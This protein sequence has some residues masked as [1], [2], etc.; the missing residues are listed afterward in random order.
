MKSG[1]VCVFGEVLFDHFP[2]GE[3]V[4][5]GAPFNVAWH[6]QAFGRA[7]YLISRVGADAEGEQ[8]QTAMRE[9]N[10]TMCGVGVDDRLPTGR[11]DVQFKNGEPRYDIVYPTAFDA[12]SGFQM[13]DCAWLYHGT[14]AARD[15]TSRESLARLKAQLSAGV[16][17]DVN[18]RDPWW[19]TD[20]VLE[21]VSGA[22]WVKLNGEELNRLSPHP[23]SGDAADEFIA[24][25]RVR[26]GILVTH[27]AA[28]AVLHTVSGEQLAVRPERRVD[29]VDTVGAGDAFA[30][31]LIHGLTA[32][33]SLARTLQRAQSFASEVVGVRGAT[34]DDRDFYR[35]VTASWNSEN[36]LNC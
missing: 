6:L 10:M 27:G 36:R 11:V 3:T 20:A 2:N 19:R 21:L 25:N 26:G 23:G 4:L 16:F 32:G 5:G 35:R 31:V 18:L 33:W 28:G 24:A 34:L 13:P 8:V 9:W 15:R 12:I 29:V 17:V 30:A 22:D 7:P 1:D 14:L